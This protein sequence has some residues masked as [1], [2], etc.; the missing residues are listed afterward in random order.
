MKEKQIITIGRQLG[1]GGREVGR[2]LSQDLGIPLYDKEL[3][4]EAAKKSW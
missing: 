2:R 4:D 3:L 1:S